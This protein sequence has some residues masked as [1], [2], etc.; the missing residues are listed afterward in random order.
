MATRKTRI[1]N[2]NPRNYRVEI[3]LN[4]HWAP[5]YNAEQHTH[6]EALVLSAECRRHGDHSR[7]VDLTDGSIV[8]E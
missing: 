4:G 8:P 7:V 5:M 2:D 3:E 1:M 6:A